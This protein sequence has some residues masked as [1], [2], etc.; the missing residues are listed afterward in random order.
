MSRWWAAAAAVVQAKTAGL[1]GRNRPERQ[2]SNSL[3][4]RW[5]S[6][7]ACQAKRDGLEFGRE[8]EVKQT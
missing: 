1:F 3:K 4:R 6:L 8:F 7:V 2:L 5:Q